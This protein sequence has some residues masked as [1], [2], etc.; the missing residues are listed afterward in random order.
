M[1]VGPEVG[2]SVGAVTFEDIP[3]GVAEALRVADALMY[4][5]KRGGKD[6]VAFSVVAGESARAVA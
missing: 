3:H 1:T 4:D 6:R 2:C 5:A